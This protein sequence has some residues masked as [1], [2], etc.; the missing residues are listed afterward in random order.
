MT[1]VTTETVVFT[2]RSGVLGVLLARRP[3][4]HWMLPGGALTDGRGLAAT[5]QGALSDQA[6][7]SGVDLE[8]LCT[9]DHPGG[10]RV[11]FMALISADRHALAPGP[12]LVEVRWFDHDDLPRLDEE[13]A[14]TVHFARDRLRAKTAY[15]PI[16]VQL[17][18]G[19]FALGQ[20]QSVY[21]A[22]LNTTLDPRNFRRDVLAAG[23]VEPTGEVRSDGPGRPARMLRWVGGDFAVVPSE[24]RGARAISRLGTSD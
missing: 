15:A 7:V 18:P 8:Q 22:V 10:V 1:L 21:E 19:V 14:D 17:L 23:I 12:D 13:T 2:I 16:A 4:N 11:A 9:F 20:L 5:A 3:G 24:R 6:G